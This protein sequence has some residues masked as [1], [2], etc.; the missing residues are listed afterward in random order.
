LT[1]LVRDN[2]ATVGG[3]LGA[4]HG[5]ALLWRRLPVKARFRLWRLELPF[6]AGIAIAAVPASGSAWSRVVWVLTGYVVG[7]AVIVGLWTAF[8]QVNALGDPA[9]RETKGLPQFE[10][11]SVKSW[12]WRLYISPLAVLRYDEYLRNERADKGEE[13]AAPPHPG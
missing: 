8:L 13:G 9:I 12:N 6:F 10:G 7:Q 5:I 1:N 11:R 2:L 3:I 4:L